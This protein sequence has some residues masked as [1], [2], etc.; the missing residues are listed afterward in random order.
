MKQH[1]PTYM[2]IVLAI[3]LV[4][5]GTS[6]TEPGPEVGTL[7]LNIQMSSRSRALIPGETPLEV[8]RYIVMGTGPQGA[9]FNV[10]TSTK[11]VDIE[12]LLLGEWT[13]RAI[14]QNQGGIDL[15]E[16]TIETIIGT[17]PNIVVIELN[18]LI[19]KGTLNLTL[20][21][22]ELEIAS[23]STTLRLIDSEG[24]TRTLNPTVNNAAN[25]SV[26]YQELLDAGSYTVTAQ[27]ENNGEPI[28]GFADFIRIVSNRTTEAHITFEIED[29]T[30]LPASVTMVDHLGT[31]IEC[32]IA[33]LPEEVPAFEPVT[34][35]LSSD[36]D[37]VIDAIWYLDGVE[38][39]RG[40]E[41]TF[42]T[43]IGSH[44]LDVLAQGALLASLG[45]ATISFESQVIG[46]AG[47][48]VLLRNVSSS[49]DQITIDAG[50]ITKLLPDN[51]VIVGN[52]TEQAIHVCRIVRG[53]LQV[54]HTYTRA[55]SGYHTKKLTDIYYDPL[56]SQVII[57]DED[58][59]R[60]SLYLYNPA[61]HELTLRLVKDNIY[62][63]SGSTILR[64]DSLSNFKMDKLNGY[65]YGL[66]GGT[67]EITAVLIN[68]ATA[69]ELKQNVGQAFYSS[70]YE[71]S[72][73][74]TSPSSDHTVLVSSEFNCLLLASRSE[75]NGT[76]VQNMKLYRQETPYITGARSVCFIGEETFVYSTADNLVR[77]QYAAP[78]NVMNQTDVYRKGDGFGTA[79]GI[80]RMVASPSMRYL[81][82]LSPSERTLDVYEISEGNQ[83]LFH[84]ETLSMGSFNGTHMEIS[85]DGTHLIITSVTSP[86][87]LL[88]QIC[89]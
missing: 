73:W 48:P 31:P 74:D 61:T 78:G 46:T 68:S 13:I 71:F 27:L 67:N 56:S 44:R 38:I 53:S 79:R 28:A 35:F 83:E 1:K 63:S 14:G 17:A 64:F 84:I 4:I 29:Y 88:Y 60:V 25:G 54:L 5:M 42:R 6:C 72:D 50:C 55:M 32:E 39:A 77:C 45:S 41:C 85:P 19:G 37:A 20:N 23:P 51:I 16:G 43:A 80:T 8:A 69:E 11:S 36:S 70:G 82:T 21:W 87:L 22:G 12:G 33:G 66:I 86:S 40:M 18:E 59:P 26:T 10:S 81:Y 47:V 58:G 34:V 52:N 30:T 62:Y 57:S 75:H 76:M 15:V 65:L 24:N 7:T 49:S 2:L 9:T 3:T 89:D